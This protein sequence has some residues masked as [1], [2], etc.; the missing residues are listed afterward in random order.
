MATLDFRGTKVSILST[1]LERGFGTRMRIWN[2]DDADDADFL[3][4]GL[5]FGTRMTQMTRI[6]KI[7]FGNF[8]I[9]GS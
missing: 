5:G 1:V 2:A 9:K 3:E 7:A 8:V 6:L 4:R